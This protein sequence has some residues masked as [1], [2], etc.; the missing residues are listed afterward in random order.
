MS[1]AGER[2]LF[3]G[4]LTPGFVKPSQ[5]VS[6]GIFDSDASGVCWEWGI[7]VGVG[8]VWSWCTSRLHTWNR[9]GARSSQIEGTGGHVRVGGWA[10]WGQ[11]M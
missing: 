5:S 8:A 2:N 10:V 11:V 7:L 4:P 9:S 1:L 6:M 3:C